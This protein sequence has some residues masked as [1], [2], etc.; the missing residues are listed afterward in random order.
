MG[1]VQVVVGGAVD[2]GS[3]RFALVESAVADDSHLG[4]LGQLDHFPMVDIVG[5]DKLRDALP[6]RLLEQLETVVELKTDVGF[7]ESG[8]ENGLLGCFGAWL[9]EYFD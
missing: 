6:H 4:V 7:G 3:V 1:D 8:L 2:F 5:H 9:A